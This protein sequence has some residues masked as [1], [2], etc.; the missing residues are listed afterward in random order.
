ME[1]VS[2]AEAS[3]LEGQEYDSFK[4]TLQRNPYT[5]ETKTEPAEKGGK[6]QMFIAVASLSVKAQQKY[7]REQQ[8]LRREELRAEGAFDD[9]LDNAPWYVGVDFSAYVKKY[10]QQFFAASEIAKAVERYQEEKGSCNRMELVKELAERIGKSDKSFYRYIKRWCEGAFWADEMLAQTG[11]NYE[12]YKIL[13]CANEPKVF[14]KPALTEDMQREIAKIASSELY[15]KNNQSVMMLY[16]DF[17]RICGANSWKNPSYNTVLRYVKELSS[18]YKDALAL[19]KNGVRDFRNK[20]MMKRH[21]NNKALQVMELVMADGH[22]FDFWCSVKRS[23]GTLDAIRPLLVGIIDARTRCLLGWVICEICNAQ[24]VKRLTWAMMYPKANNCIYGVPRV[25]YIDNGKEFTAK[26]L[27]GIN[28]KERFSLDSETEGFYKA[29]GIEVCK[30]ALPYQGWTKAQV[31]RFFGTVCTRFSKRFPSY[32][33]TLTGSKTS[34]KVKKDIK[35]MLK[36]GELPTIDDVAALFEDWLEND[37]HISIHQGLK[38]QSEENPVPI[39]VFKAAERY[40][41]APPPMALARTFLLN[42]SVRTVFNVGIN[43]FGKTFQSAAL[44]G[45]IGEKVNVRYNDDERAMIFVYNADGE[46]VCEIEANEGLNPLAGVADKALESHIIDQQRQIKRAREQGAKL[47]GK[48][49]AEPLLPAM[50]REPPVVSMPK[51]EQFKQERKRREK[52]KTINVNEYLEKQAMQ[53]IN[54]F[55]KLA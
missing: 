10:Q 19:I 7:K 50:K 21:R 54:D 6:E 36:R 11:E 5:Y 32:T 37:Y 18:E 42:A 43:I 41:K 4:K 51:D 38:K 24:T 14:G 22:H 34:G 47:Q 31:E 39:E 55:N 2:L 40:F 49:R 20:N 9:Y 45:Y 48:D 35:G 8:K 23:N 17:C 27:T 52:K 30:R 44:S 16:E 12:Y 28:R 1:W 33:G 3:R 26:C 25:L 13:A 29:V 46:F 53:A 15:L